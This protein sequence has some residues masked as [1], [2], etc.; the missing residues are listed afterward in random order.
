MDS[1]KENNRIYLSLSND[2]ALVFFDWLSRLNECENAAL[3]QD[4]AEERI[5]FDLEALLEK[6]VTIIFENDYGNQLLR[7]REHIRDDE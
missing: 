1:K 6:T 3:F 2:E 5:L 4:Q 7:A